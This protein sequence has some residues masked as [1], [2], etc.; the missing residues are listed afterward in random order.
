MLNYPQVKQ[1]FRIIRHRHTLKTG[2]DPRSGLGITS[3]K[4]TPSG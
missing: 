1:V 2:V 3:S 4:P